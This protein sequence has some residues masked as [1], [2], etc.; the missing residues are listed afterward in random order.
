VLGVDPS[1]LH[2]CSALK[3]LRININ[4]HVL[5]LSIVELKSVFIRLSF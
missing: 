5:E 3:Y 1:C 2:K 4:N